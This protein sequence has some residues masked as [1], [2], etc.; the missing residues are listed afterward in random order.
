MYTTD[1]ICQI[2]PGKDEILFSLRSKVSKFTRTPI[3]GGSFEILLPYRN[4]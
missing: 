3:S 4:N 1:N 2:L